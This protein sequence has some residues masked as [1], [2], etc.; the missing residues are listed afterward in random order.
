[1]KSFLN[2]F[3]EAKLPSSVPGIGKKLGLAKN[4]R[5]AGMWSADVKPNKAVSLEKILS[6]DPQFRLD[7]KTGKYP[8]HYFSNNI[9]VS[10]FKLKDGDNIKVQ[11]KKLVRG[12]S[13]GSLQST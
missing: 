7:G 1:M 4:L 3:Q 9:A 12:H 5:H 8:N 11:A 6:G 10:F 2:Y 13:Q